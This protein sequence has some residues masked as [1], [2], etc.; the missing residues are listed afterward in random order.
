MKESSEPAMPDDFA[1]MAQSF[2]VYGIGPVQRPQELRPA[3]RKALKVVKQKRLPA[4]V[5]V[6]CEAG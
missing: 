2:G 4:L 5:D 6:I 3:L 1:K